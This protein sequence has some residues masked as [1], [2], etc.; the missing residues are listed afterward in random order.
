MY[1]SK[2]QSKNPSLDKDKP[3]INAN[4]LKKIMQADLVIFN[5]YQ[6]L[7]GDQTIW[8][9]KLS[10]FN[11][12]LSE[13]R[14]KINCWGYIGLLNEVLE[15]RKKFISNKNSNTIIQD[16]LY[17]WID[18]NESR[19]EG[20]LSDGKHLELNMAKT[21]C[22]QIFYTNANIMAGLGILF[23]CWDCGWCSYHGI[24]VDK[25]ESKSAFL[26]SP[27][28]SSKGL[29]SYISTL[30]FEQMYRN[31]IFI[32]DMTLYKYI[33]NTQ[34]N[35]N[36][37]ITPDELDLLLNNKYFYD[38]NNINNKKKFNHTL[39]YNSYSDSDTNYDSD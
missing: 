30:D 24:S 19:F 12:E 26:V 13:K 5:A 33:E 16:Q 9:T 17:V 23:L 34:I 37:Q 29:I 38:N 7:E 10:T 35:F 21:A 18:A 27:K 1:S 6:T 20:K 8:N 25:I 2:Y 39:V 22:K 32:H 15:A 3:L 14:F 28:L 4:L 11:P 36:Q 31:K